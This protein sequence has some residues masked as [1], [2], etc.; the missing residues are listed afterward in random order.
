MSNTS[1]LSLLKIS[2]HILHSDDFHVEGYALCLFILGLHDHL[3]W[4]VFF[5][6]IIL[7]KKLIK[8]PVLIVLLLLITLRFYQY[9][10]QHIPDY[11]S[12][13]GRITH[14]ESSTYHDQVIIDINHQ[15]FQLKVTKNAYRLGD[16]LK[17]EAYV[18][19]FRKQT[20]PFGFNAKQY[21]LSKGVLGY[22]SPAEVE[23][24]DHTFHIGFLRSKL[25]IYMNQFKSSDLMKTMLLGDNGLDKVEK[26][27][28]RDLG[29]LHLLSL[30]GL[31]I[32]V[33]VSLIEKLLFYFSIPKNTQKIIVLIIYLIFFYVNSFSMSSTRLL[34]MFL[35]IWINEV[36]KLRFSK[37]DLLQFVFAIML[38]VEINLIFHLGFLITYLILNFLYLLKHLYST[39]NSYSKRLII[40]IIILF[41]LL[42]FQLS[43]SPLILFIFP[44]LMSIIIYP[45]FLGLI[46]TLFIPEL[47]S[48]M[49]QGI[50]L[51]NQGLEIIRHRN[52]TF[53]LPALSTHLIIL[54]YVCVIYIFRSIKFKV[55]TIRTIT[56]V[57]VFSL[58]QIRWIEAK[59][60]RLYFLDVGQ[61]DTIYIESN[62]CNIMVDSYTNS[63]TFLRNMGVYHLDYL[64]LTHSD[65]DHIKE[66]IDVINMIQVKYLYVSAFDQGYPLFNIKSKKAKRGD[67]IICGDI[68]VDFLAPF[69]EMNS[70]NNVSLVFKLSIYGKSILFT[71]DIEKEAENE[72]AFFYKDYLKSDILK[73]AHHGSNTSTTQS[74]LDYVDP[75]HAIIS[76]GAHNRYGFPNSEITSRLKQ[77]GIETYQTDRLGT[78]ILTLSEKKEKWAFYLPF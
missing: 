36:H 64:I 5:V 19:Q 50:L 61:G 62:N 74:F 38:L 17:I 7:T 3:L 60:V 30:S 70:P 43:I 10:Q 35:F 76:V 29:I 32:Y 27:L 42:P 68:R 28:Y 14:I 77:R 63:S 22:L 26:E 23:Y 1:E 69:M 16:Q 54:Y 4:I 52:I 40:S 45:I 71:G 15:K 48:I 58:T 47:D 18:N 49:Y 25:S 11:I 73:I 51:L 34:L 37:L 39:K 9:T 67:S 44:L 12:G 78:I 13:V 24:I 20:M 6:Y 55:M 75:Q 65:N 31:H 72:L 33:V 57:L 66:A 59:E 56:L 2:N 21:Y 41:V 53:Y 46:A 8:I